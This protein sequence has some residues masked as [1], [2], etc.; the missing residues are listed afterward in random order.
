MHLGPSE[1]AAII[2]MLG[3]VALFLI[4]FFAPTKKP[5]RHTPQTWDGH[6]EICACGASAGDRRDPETGQR[7]TFFSEWSEP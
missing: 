3:V 2:I 5:H 1:W 7:Y 6:H 4:A